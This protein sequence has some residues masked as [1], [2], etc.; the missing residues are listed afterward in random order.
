MNNEPEIVKVIGIV[1]DVD[2]LGRVVIPKEMRTMFKIDEMVEMIVTTKG[3]LLRN[4]RYFLVNKYKECENDEYADN[5]GIDWES[6]D[7]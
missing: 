5:N 4:P 6:I 2:K 1:K 7:T 3:I